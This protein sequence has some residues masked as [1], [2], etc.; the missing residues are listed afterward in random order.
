EGGEVNGIGPSVNPADLKTAQDDLKK[1]RT[2]LVRECPMGYRC[3]AKL[4]DEANALMASINGPIAAP[5][6]GQK[7]VMAELKEETTQ[8]IAELNR[9]V[10]TSIKKINEQM[11]AQPHI[12]TGAP[13][14]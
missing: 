14:R 11:A 7:T 6:E 1:L 5:T 13:I 8:V 2:K 4:R 3:P 9:I 10:E 12:T